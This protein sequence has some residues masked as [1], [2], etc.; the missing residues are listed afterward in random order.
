VFSKAR[1]PFLWGEFPG[2]FAY[3]TDFRGISCRFATYNRSRLNRWQVDAARGT[4]SGELTGPS[5]RLEF[6]AQMTGGGK[7][8]APLD[9]RMDREIT[10]SITASLRIAV[11]DRSGSIVF[12]G[13]SSEVGMEICL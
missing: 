6:E 5:G 10:E 11:F 8:R 13:V 1:I 2:F 4:C 12:Q 7:L 3:F 9:G